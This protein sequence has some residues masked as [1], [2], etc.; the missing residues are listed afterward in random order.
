MV[1]AARAP[2]PAATP[3][4]AAQEAVDHATASTG[5]PLPVAQR[6]AF[7][8]SLG[9]DLSGVRVHTD[10][11]SAGA[12]GAISAR[13][14]AVNQDIHFGAGQYQPGSAAGDHLLAHEVAHTVQQRGGAAHAPQAKLEIS[15]PGD[16]AEV[17]A[18]GAAD[19]MVAGAPARVTAAAPAIA[20]APTGAAPAPATPAAPVPAAGDVVGHPTPADITAAERFAGHGAH[21]PRSL[22]PGTGL[23]GFDAT[24]T[25][26]PAGPGTLQIDIHAAVN[27]VDPIRAGGGGQAAPTSPD[28]QPM[29]DA[30]NALKPAQRAALIPQFTW[31]TAAAERHKWMEQL[32]A[33][34]EST[35]SH[36]HEFHV[37]R[38]GWDWIGS[39]VGVNVTVAART[40]RHHGDHVSVDAVKT[41][42]NTNLYSFGMFSFCAAGSEKNAHDQ[43][44]R[45]SS[46][47]VSPR[48]DDLLRKTSIHFAD[49]SAALDADAQGTLIRWVRT[50]Q[51]DP[52]NPASHAVSIDVEGFASRSGSAKHNQDLSERRV[53][54]VVDFM[55]SN[56][57]T[58][59]KART[60]QVG[61]GESVADQT[62]ENANDRRVDI[63]IEHSSS[64]VLA[65]HEFGHAFG[66]GDQYATSDTAGNPTTITGTGA[67]TGQAAAHD[68]L[69]KQMQDQQGH[70]LPGAIFENNAGIMSGGDQVLAEDYS[71]FAEALRK[72]SGVHEWALGAPHPKA[73]VVAAASGTHHAAAPTTASSAAP[74]PGAGAG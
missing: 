62:T 63:K 54:A 4:P 52:A 15:S 7:E 44:I 37:Q 56:G 38:A 3:A 73:S 46:A 31:A 25:P 43:S 60:T 53:K 47:D 48:P 27:F 23:G 36:R 1:Y 12:A 42:P 22:V 45:I 6:G 70:H 19:A 64:Q 40:S 61:R 11:E 8:R 20:R 72:V 50:Y 13:A 74:H 55:A 21:G 58:H 30:L 67:Q 28:Y 57:F 29:A 41:P 2:G 68:G 65:A 24:Y 32:K 9:T 49:G 26:T 39:K 59:V 69:T 18:D 10:H 34:V 71:T 14:F 35:W 5:E 16:T 33:R 17:E 66:L 51:G